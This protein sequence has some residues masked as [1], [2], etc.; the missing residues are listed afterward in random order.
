M[1][2][3]TEM[4]FYTGNHWNGIYIYFT[5]KSQFREFPV[6]KLTPFKKHIYPPKISLSLT[7]SVALLITIKNKQF[8]AALG[9][10]AYID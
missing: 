9:A 7:Q 10:G 2:S 8:F 6:E 3:L 5:A 4:F 1:L